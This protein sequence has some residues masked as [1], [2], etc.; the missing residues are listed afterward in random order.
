MYE[1]FES[2][3]SRRCISARPARSVRVWIFDHEIMI[4]V[5][6]KVRKR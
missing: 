5:G 1:V 3:A 6:L 2:G 4:V